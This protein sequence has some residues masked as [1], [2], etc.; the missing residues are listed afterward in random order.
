MLPVPA[1]EAMWNSLN[2]LE[3]QDDF[4][5]TVAFCK[6]IGKIVFVFPILYDV[7][8]LSQHHAMVSGKTSK[9]LE[10]NSVVPQAAGVGVF[11]W[12]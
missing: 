1:L 7:F 11:P 3:T 10:P 5:F 4:I 9:K 12:E 6:M 2:E 8:K